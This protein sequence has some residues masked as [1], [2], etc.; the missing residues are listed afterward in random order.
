M[1]MKRPDIRVSLAIIALYGC[2]AAKGTDL[3]KQALSPAVAD[4]AVSGQIGQ[5]GQQIVPAARDVSGVRLYVR[6]DQAAPFLRGRLTNSN[7]AMAEE[8]VTS[9]LR[10]WPVAGAYW[11]RLAEIRAASG[12]DIQSVIEAYQMS[13]LVAPFDG[14]TMVTRQALGVRLWDVLSADDR[15]GVVADL[16]STWNALPP[17]L[18]ISLHNAIASLSPDGRAR[19]KADLKGRSSLDDRQL[20]EI[21]L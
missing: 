20:T 11:E 18:T 16:A 12:R 1:S 9:V 10:V 8:S 7:V 17:D 15:R 13:V 6:T 14:Q 5:P 4:P 19:L 21:G 3:V 2:V